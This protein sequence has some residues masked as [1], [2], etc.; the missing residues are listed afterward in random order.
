VDI[1]QEVDQLY[2]EP[3]PADPLI[4]AVRDTAS[5]PTVDRICGS[6]N[7]APYL[8]RLWGLGG[9]LQSVFVNSGTAGK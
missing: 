8:D 6:G 4:V 3:P 5:V 1:I 2:P 9:E 7:P